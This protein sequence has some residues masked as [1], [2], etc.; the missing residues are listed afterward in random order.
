MPHDNNFQHPRGEKR[1]YSDHR[2]DSISDISGWKS[3]KT[4]PDSRQGNQAGRFDGGVDDGDSSSVIDL[5][6]DDDDGVPDLR[7][8]QR[9]AAETYRRNKKQEEED[10]RIAM[11]LQEGAYDFSD[12]SDT[13]TGQGQPAQPGPSAFNQIPSPHRSE[14][15]MQSS[16]NHNLPLHSPQ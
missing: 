8:Q 6:K 3:R 5:T 16:T 7:A 11:L 1:S 10:A 2:G 14:M 15:P 4:T 13:W 9:E 12:L